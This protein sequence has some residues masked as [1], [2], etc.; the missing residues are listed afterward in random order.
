[1]VPHAGDVTTQP[2]RAHPRNP[3][4]FLFRGEPTLLITSG[5]H[6]GAVI[7]SDFDFRAYLDALVE[8][9]LNYTRIYTGAYL[10]PEH[11]FVRGNPLGPREGRACL[12][13]HRGED[14][15]FDLDRW[16]PRYFERLCDFVTEAGRRNIVVEACLFNAMYPEFLKVMPLFHA[17]NLQ[18]VGRCP[19]G[20]FQTLAE[21]AL[22]AHQAA[23]ARRIVE[24]LN[25]FDNVIL[26]IC[27]EPGIQGTA[28]EDYTPWLLHLAEV[29]ADTESRMPNRHL[30]AQ[31]IC[32]T[33][34]GP[35]DVSRDPRI[36]VL[37]GQYIEGTA[38]G[39][40]GGMQLLDALYDRGKPI[41]LNETAYYPGWYSGDV[42][43]AARAEAWEFIVGGGAGFN[44]LNA[45]FSTSNPAARGVGNELV[46]QGLRNL[47]VFMRSF[48]L[49]RVRRDDSLIAGPLPTGIRARALSD[50]GRQYG[51]YLHHSRCDQGMKYVVEP[52]EHVVE[53]ELRVAPA[54][55]ELEW[56]DP[57]TGK[58]VKRADVE[59]PG[60]TCRLESPVHAIDL[61]LHIRRSE[62]GAAGK[63]IV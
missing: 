34:D 63:L 1:M 27:D 62:H 53:L 42:A 47:R 18:G 61:A 52:G 20:G 2:I 13:W 4:V 36:T 28:P 22:V 29:V 10:E 15:R 23:Y 3:H 40:L 26:E 11:T 48:D 9:E 17:N 60:G 38:G 35:G 24:A 39:Q 41:E 12:P 5:E 56:I 59:H 54:R 32:G 33:F 46:L 25:P 14:G 45:L 51:L 30:V 7:N 6:Y 21:P 57:A 8:Y 43:A 58:L 55:Y 49:V 37:T 50:P 31:Q 19:A 44:Q 16:S